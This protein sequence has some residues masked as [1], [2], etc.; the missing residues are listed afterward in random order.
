MLDNQTVSKLRD[1]KL[2]TMVQ[3]LSEP[4]EMYR[5]LSFEE[6]FGMMVEKEWLSKKNNKIK[7]LLYKL[8]W[9]WMHV[10]KI[11]IIH[12]TGK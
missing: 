5:G 4:E 2:K 9:V 6:R 1:M 7:R 10:W 11:L 3:M 12:L 8:H